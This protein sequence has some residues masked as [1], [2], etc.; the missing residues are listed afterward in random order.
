MT[1][2]HAEQRAAPAERI[3]VRCVGLRCAPGAAAR[4][5]LEY[6]PEPWRTRYFLS[7]PVGEK[8]YYDA[9]TTRMPTRCGS[10]PS[11]PTASSPA[12]IRS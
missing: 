8:I 10:T 7:H 4:V 9:P 12:V 1:L 11:P 3:A 2:T 5:L 6:I